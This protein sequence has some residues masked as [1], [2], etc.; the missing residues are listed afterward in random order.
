MYKTVSEAEFI[1][2]I[3]SLDERLEKIKL[4]G[5]EIT[6]EQGVIRYNFICDKTVDTDLQNRILKEAEKITPPAF[7]NVEISVKKIRFRQ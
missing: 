3:K 5:I 2:T 6:K 1:S 4:S 7:N